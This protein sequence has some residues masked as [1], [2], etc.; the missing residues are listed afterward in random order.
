[1]SLY[2]ALGERLYEIPD[3]P[4]YLTDLIPLLISLA[5]LN[6]YIEKIKK[7]SLAVTRLLGL[8]DLN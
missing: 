4:A 7:P 1:M 3:G 6:Y 5:S 2:D 8:S